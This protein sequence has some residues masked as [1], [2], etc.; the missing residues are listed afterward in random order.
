M[1]KEETSENRYMFSVPGK[2]KYRS[3]M[4]VA[5]RISLTIY[6]NQGDRGFVLFILV[7]VDLF[8]CF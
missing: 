6:F 8:W 1:R 4:V 3:V 2:F 7:W 5:E